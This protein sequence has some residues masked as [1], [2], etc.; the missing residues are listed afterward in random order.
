MLFCTNLLKNEYYHYHHRIRMIRN[1]YGTKPKLMSTEKKFCTDFFTDCL[2]KLTDM[3]YY[4][5]NTDGPW[6]IVEDVFVFYLFP[7]F[8]DNNLL[9][10][11]KFL[12]RIFNLKKK[13]SKMIFNP[14]FTCC[15]L[16]EMQE[17]SITKITTV[18]KWKKHAI[19][20]VFN[21]KRTMAE[22]RF[23]TSYQTC[24]LFNAIVLAETSHYR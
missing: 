5:L 21:S 18:V 13:N 2:T 20:M 14:T 16:W 6:F 7:L 1:V 19:F 4:C 22:K 9:G 24:G 3:G 10:F 15:F 11:H 17:R 12:K 8:L 23:L